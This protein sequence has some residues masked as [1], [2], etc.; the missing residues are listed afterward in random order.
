MNSGSPV[1][2]RL[3]G[4]R[5]LSGGYIL[6]DMAEIDQVIYLAILTCVFEG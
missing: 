4:R 6:G 2:E 1:A 5:I 3:A